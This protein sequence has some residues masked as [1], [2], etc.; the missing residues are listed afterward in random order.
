MTSDRSILVWPVCVCVF[1][2]GLW[3]TVADGVWAVLGFG[4]AFVSVIQTARFRFSDKMGHAAGVCY[5]AISLI[6]SAGAAVGFLKFLSLW[7]P[8][9]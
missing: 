2:G 8:A 5:M 7:A 9:V 4:L 1:C 3:M 6:L